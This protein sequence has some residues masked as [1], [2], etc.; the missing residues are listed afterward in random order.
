MNSYG[1]SN[2]WRTPCRL[3][4]LGRHHCLLAGIQCGCAGSETLTKYNP[5][6]PVWQNDLPYPRKFNGLVC[7][8]VH[9]YWILLCCFVLGSEAIAATDYQLIS[10]GTA[11][12]V[13]PLRLLSWTLPHT[14]PQIL[15][16][17]RGYWYAGNFSP[18]LCISVSGHGSGL[19][20]SINR[21]L[22]S[23]ERCWGFGESLALLAGV[24]S[25]S[26][27]LL[28]YL[29]VSYCCWHVCFMVQS[30]S[31]FPRYVLVLMQRII[32]TGE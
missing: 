32:T 4:C 9:V 5:L 29:A 3:N 2:R 26:A 23:G 1:I 20:A 11:K 15:W 18:R 24:C 25:D 8:S 14:Y 17:T 22:F 31:V 21:S 13:G 12:C 28:Y 7:V 27:T 10:P 6:F 19:V 16:V 30:C